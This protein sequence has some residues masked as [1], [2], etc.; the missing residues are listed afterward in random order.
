M[1][2]ACERA[3]K[4]VEYFALDL[5]LSELERTF[6]EIPLKDYRHV[7]FSALHGT[8][9]DGLEWLAE[10]SSPLTPT[11]LLSMGSSIGNFTRDEAADFLQGFANVL[12]PGDTILIGLDACLSRERVHK[13]YN[14]DQ[15]TTHEFYR[16]GLDHANKLF[17]YKAFKQEDWDTVG[18]YDEV[19][20]R[21]EAFYRALKN[22][23]VGDTA[24][25]KGDKLKLEVA[26]KYSASQSDELWRKAGLIHQTAYGNTSG[27]YRTYPSYH[28]RNLLACFGNNCFCI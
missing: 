28:V 2:Q 6:S 22:V 11:C 17:G 25:K 20:G 26:Y 23:W 16:N 13:A 14:D 15:G 10:T 5:S 19:A 21:H 3:E 27:D 9:D 24:F 12:G 7:S 18:R 1:L 8:Y 4:P